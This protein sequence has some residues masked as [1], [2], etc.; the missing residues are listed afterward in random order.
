MKAIPVETSAGTF[1]ATFSERGLARLNFPCADISAPLTVDNSSVPEK[2]L[3]RWKKLTQA[4]LEDALHGRHLAMLPPLDFQNGTDFQRDVWNALR[5][6]PAGCTRSY[7]EIARAIGK[8]NAFRAV[9]QACGA[10]P[11][12]VLV[13]CHRVLA[14]HRKLGGFSGGLDWKKRLLAAEGVGAA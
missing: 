7:A 14:A 9:G 1:R 11:I 8:P 5:S 12:P 3:V 10:N 6:I 4:A 13:P 2:V